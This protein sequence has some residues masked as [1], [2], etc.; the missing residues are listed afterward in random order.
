MTITVNERAGLYRIGRFVAATDTW[1]TIAVSS[2][3]AN[4]FD[5]L[6]NAAVGDAVGF[7]SRNAYSIKYAGIDFDISTALTA[8][9]IEGVW[10]YAV[11]DATV[12]TNYGIRWEPL[13][14]V[15]DDTNKFQN[16]GANTVTWLIPQDWHNYT[17]WSSGHNGSGGY[18]EWCVRFRVTA[19]SGM[20]DGGTHSGTRAKVIRY[21]ISV[22]NQDSTLDDIYDGDQIGTYELTSRTATAVDSAAVPNRFFMNGR[23]VSLSPNRQIAL[24]VTA[25]TGFTSVTIAIA[26]LDLFGTAQSESITVSA[27]SSVNLTNDYSQIYTTEVTAVTGSGSIDF[28]LIQT[29]WGFITKYGA[30]QFT[31]DVSLYTSGT[32]TLTIKNKHVLFTK[33]TSI[34]VRSPI[35]Y[36]ELYG[37][38]GINGNSIIFELEDADYI[39]ISVGYSDAVFCDTV[40]KCLN[41]NTGIHIHGFWGGGIGQDVRQVL[42]GVTL[43]G[44]RNTSFTNKVNI[45]ADTKVV[46]THNEGN[47]CIQLN[48][49]YVAN[50][51]GI[52][53]SYNRPGATL[54]KL[55][56]T[57]IT[58][59]CVQPWQSDRAAGWIETY[60]D[61]NWGTKTDALK[62][63][64][65]NQNMVNLD[66]VVYEAYSVMLHATDKNGVPVANATLTITDGNSNTVGTYTSNVDG[67]FGV[68]SGQP[69]SVVDADSIF[70]TTKSFAT[71]ELWHGLIHF[72]SGENAGNRHIIYKDHTA[73][74]ITFAP[75]MVTLA[76]TSS[77]YIIV[78]IINVKEYAHSSVT[79]NTYNYGDV[80]DSNPYTFTITAD[81]Y[82]THTVTQVV[83]SA[84]DAGVKLASSTAIELTT[85]TIIHKIDEDKVILL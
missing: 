24:D 30:N 27:A 54:H 57:G 38:K 47:G 2:A 66:A 68:Y 62:I 17:N 65:R 20:T 84:I 43:Q 69:T 77:Q 39:G 80:T 49:T 18:Y 40:F 3:G 22:K 6:S 72:T 36:G 64:F 37:D 59:P 9:T 71:E 28:A 46:G 81:G 61:C 12:N 53:S 51:I 85:S 23:T 73:T 56:F 78:P 10:E 44:F 52:R 1:S 70:D 50:S 11:F 42:A 55:D 35:E 74:E 26:G 41:L 83:D 60:C 82:E 58:G 34:H 15:V 13:E 5:F 8:S 33:N 48:N 21:G 14:Y 29:C 67:Y 25:F 7:A 76:D 79:P 4:N 19:V 31:F 45:V 75:R 16:T 63:Q 32:G